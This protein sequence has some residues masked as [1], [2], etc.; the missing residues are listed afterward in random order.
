MKVEIKN[1][2]SGSVKFTAEIDASF[3]T[4]DR[5]LQIGAAVKWGIKEEADL[6]GAD[7]RGADLRGAD[8]REAKLR[9]ANL[10]GAN[11]WG[12]DLRGA[13]LWGA[14]LWGANLWGADL[15][16]ANLWGADLRGANLWGANLWGAPIIDA[17]VDARGYI[18]RATYDPKN[19]ELKITAGCRTWATIDEARTHFGETYNSNGDVAECLA[20]IQYIETV[21]ESRK[22][23]SPTPEGDAR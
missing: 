20:K 13:N 12:A 1:R 5:S 2:F 9:G 22:A 7:L 23:L 14:N 19:F 16:G 15:R 3:E 11:L 17:G 18:F 4:K 10:R 21:F 6:R 8:L